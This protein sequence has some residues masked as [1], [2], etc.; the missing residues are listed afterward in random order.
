[1]LIKFAISPIALL[2]VINALISG[3]MCWAANSETL[4]PRANSLWNVKAKF[5]Q[6]D[7]KSKGTPNPGR[8]NTRKPPAGARD[9]GPPLACPPGSKRNAAGDC[10]P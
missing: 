4:R 1:V 9:L 6:A 3:S 5:V 8:P 7:A 2:L 10:R